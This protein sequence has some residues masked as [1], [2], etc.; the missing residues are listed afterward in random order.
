MG[1]WKHCKNILCIRADNMGDVI[2]STPALRALKETFDC[3]ITL[4]TSASGAVISEYLDQVDEVMAVDLPWVKYPETGISIDMIG[5]TKQIKDRQFDGAI[6]FTVYSQSALPAAML[7]YMAGIPNRLAYSRENPYELLTEWVPDREPFELIRH[8]VERDLKLVSQINAHTTNDELSIIYKNEAYLSATNKL[9]LFVPE[10]NSWIILH[11]GVSEEKRQYPVEYWIQT[12]KMLS[13]EYRLPLLITGSKS[14]RNLADTIAGGIGRYAIS[15]A[16]MLS[17]G[18]F[19]AIV[20]K[21][22]C[23]VSVNTS[24]IHIAAAM[25]TPQV[26]LYAQTNPQHTPWKGLYKLLSFSVPEHLQSKNVIIRHVSN[27]HY[28]KYLPYPTPREV[29]TELDELLEKISQNSES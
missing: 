4:L 28:T 7:A 24:T 29:V 13:E 22:K 26:V 9:N 16:G 17:I 5:L 25:K 11:P 1:D 21:A 10:R 15:V 23:V 3:K 8:Q 27:Q 6:I 12:G 14:E 2:M 19:I 18:E 20:A